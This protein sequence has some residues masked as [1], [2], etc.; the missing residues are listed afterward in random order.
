MGSDEDGTHFVNC[1]YGALGQRKVGRFDKAPHVPVAG[2]PTVSMLDG[3]LQGGLFVRD[4]II[5]LRDMGISP[6]YLPLIPVQSKNP[7]EVWGV[8]RWSRIGVFR[9]IPKH[10]DG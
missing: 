1:V 6:I 5:A 9:P 10:Q 4:Y 8:I 3:K 7:Q 2:A